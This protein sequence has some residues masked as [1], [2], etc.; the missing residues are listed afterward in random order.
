MTECGNISRMSVVK[1]LG[2][3]LVPFFKTVALLY[4][5]FPKHEQSVTYCVFKC[6]PILCLMG[7]V[8]MYGI[9]LPEK[10]S[11]AFKVLLG[12][13]FSCI[14]DA[15]LVWTPVY[16]K[17]GMLFFA[18]AHLLYVAA[19]G[20]HPPALSL[21][22]IV[23]S[24]IVGVWLCCLSGLTGIYHVVGP[25][26]GL[27]LGLMIWRAAAQVFKGGHPIPWTSISRALGA[28]L[29]GV[30]DAI[31][32]LDMFFAHGSPLS[33]LILPTYYAAQLCITVSVAELTLSCNGQQKKS[34]RPKFLKYRDRLLPIPY[35]KL[36][37]SL[38]SEWSV[39]EQRLC[40][41]LSDGDLI[42]EL[43]EVLCSVESYIQCHG[44]RMPKAQRVALLQLT[45]SM[46]CC[47]NLDP[48]VCF[49][50]VSLSRLLMTRMK[51]LTTKSMQLDWRH[52]YD[53][54]QWLTATMEVRLGLLRWP[55]NEVEKLIKMIRLAKRFFPISSI[56]EIWLDFRHHIL[57]RMLSGYGQCTFD[58]LRLLVPFSPKSFDVIS[59]TWLPDIIDLWYI[60][61]DFGKPFHDVVGILAQVARFCR[62]RVDWEPHLERVFCGL[63]RAITLPHGPVSMDDTGRMQ[64]RSSMLDPYAELLANAIG[65]DQSKSKSTV[66]ER[67]KDFYKT[68]EPFYHPSNPRSSTALLISFSHHLVSS[69]Y[70]RL[71]DELMPAVEQ[72]ED[73]GLPPTEFNLTV[74]QIDEVVQLILPIVLDHML[75]FKYDRTVIKVARTIDFLA[76][77]RPR[78]VLPALLN[79]LED[80]LVRVESPLRYTRPLYALCF[81]VSS[82][83]FVRFGLYQRGSRVGTRSPDSSD[84]DPEDS[85]S[86]SDEPSDLVEQDHATDEVTDL[87][88]N[89]LGS[90]LIDD[91]V[92]ASKGHK[93]SYHSG[94]L[95]PS[96]QAHL[97]AFTFPE[98]RIELV[99][100]LNLLLSGFDLDYTDRVYLTIA[101]LSRL[102]LSTPIQDF[103]EL[104]ADELMNGLDLGTNIRARAESIA[105]STADVEELV[106][107]VFQRTLEYLLALSDRSATGQN[108]TG[109][110]ASAQTD[111]S[112]GSL[113][114]RPHAGPEGRPRV[115]SEVCQLSGLA[116]LSVA[117][118]IST[119]PAPHLRRRLIR[120]LVDV[121]VNS[122]WEP[123][124]ARLL[125][126]QLYWLSVKSKCSVA[127]QQHMDEI[128]DGIPIIDTDLFALN[129]LWPQFVAIYRELHVDGSIVY[130]GRAEPRLLAL[131]YVLSGCFGAI[132]PSRIV[133]A[134]FSR[135][136]LEPLV[137]ILSELLFLSTGVR[138]GMSHQSKPSAVDKDVTG[139]A[140]PALAEAA[141]SLLG[142]ILCRLASY[143]V[144]LSNV[145]LMQ[146]G[147]RHNTPNNLFLN[148]AW[149]TPFI[150]I[151]SLVEQAVSPCQSDEF[152]ST[153]GMGQTNRFASFWVLPSAETRA[154]ADQLVRQF[155]API[156]I[157]LEQINEHLSNSQNGFFGLTVADR[158]NHLSSLLIWALH[159]LVSL[160]DT[161]SPRSSDCADTDINS[162]PPWHGH[163]HL[164]PNQERSKK[165]LL[166]AELLPTLDFSYFICV[167]T[168]ARGEQIGLRDWILDV[169]LNLLTKAAD[170][171][172]HADDSLSGPGPGLISE[173]VAPVSSEEIASSKNKSLGVA[174]D[175]N[176]TSSSLFCCAHLD[177]LIRLTECAAFNWTTSE[178][179]P[180]MLLITRGPQALCL[181]DLGA[182][183]CL[184]PHGNSNTYDLIPTLKLIPSLV[185]LNGTPC[186]QQSLSDDMSLDIDCVNTFG[187]D[188][189][190]SVLSWIATVQKRYQLLSAHY[191][192]YPLN[193]AAAQHDS[194]WAWSSNIAPSPVLKRLIHVMATLA[195]APR[196]YD[197]RRCFTNYLVA[198]PLVVIPRATTE[199]TL[200]VLNRLTN[201]ETDVQSEAKQ[202]WTTDDEE[203]CKRSDRMFKLIHHRRRSSI[204]LLGRIFQKIDTMRQHD[205]FV[206]LD[207]TVMS[208]MWTALIIQAMHHAISEPEDLGRS[209]LS[210]EEIRY[211]QTAHDE[212][213]RLI[214]D[215]FGRVPRIPLIPTLHFPTLKNELNVK[216]CWLQHV[217]Q[218]ASHVLEVFHS[219]NELHT[220]SHPLMPNSPTA[221]V[222]AKRRSVYKQFI[223]DVFD[224]CLSTYQ[225]H[226]TEANQKRRVAG[227]ALVARLFNLLPR[228]IDPPLNPPWK[229]NCVQ[230][231]PPPPAP[232]VPM[233]KVSCDLITSQQPEIAHAACTYV[234]DMLCLLL[235]RHRTP[236]L[237]EVNLNT[238]VEQR[239]GE[240]PPDSGP[241]IPAPRADNLFLAFDEHACVLASDEAFQRHHHIS[242]WDVGY[243]YFPPKVILDDPQ[244]IMAYPVFDPTT[245]LL[246]ETQSDW[247][248]HLDPTDREQ[249]EVRTC[250]IHLA[251]TLASPRDETRQFWLLLG[252]R[253][254]KLHRAPTKRE[255]FPINLFVQI[256]LLAFGPDPLLHHLEALVRSILLVQPG[257]QEKFD[258]VT[259]VVAPCWALL[260]TLN[261]TSSALRWPRP[262]RYYYL[263]RVLPRLLTL[264]ELNALTVSTNG[265]AQAASCNQIHPG[266]VQLF[267]SP[268]RYAGNYGGIGNHGLSDN[269]VP[270]QSESPTPAPCSPGSK[271]ETHHHSTADPIATVPQTQAGGPIGRLAFAW[272]LLF[273][274]LAENGE[275]DISLLH[276]LWDWTQEGID[277]C[278][279]EL[280]GKPDTTGS[281][282]GHNK[283]AVIPPGCL[284]MS[285]GNECPTCLCQRCLPVAHRR[286]FY[287]RMCTTLVTYMGWKGVRLH[288][289]LSNCLP[290]GHPEVHGPKDPAWF[291]HAADNSV[292]IRDT[293][294]KVA[295]YRACLP[296]TDVFHGRRVPLYLR[297]DPVVVNPTGWKE[298][299]ARFPDRERFLTRLLVN[300]QSKELVGS[301]FVTETFLPYLVRDTITVLRLKGY[302]P[303]AASLALRCAPP[304]PS[305][306]NESNASG[307]L[308]AQQD[309]AVAVS[310]RDKWIEMTPLANRLR[311]MY[312]CLPTM[313]SHAFPVSLRPDHMASGIVEN[314]VSALQFCHMLMPLL[315]D[316]CSTGNLYRTISHLL[317]MGTFGSAGFARVAN[318][319]T[320]DE[321]LDGLESGVG[322]VLRRFALIPLAGQGDPDTAI[323]TCLDLARPMLAHG[324]WKTRG[325]GLLLLRNLVVVNLPAFWVTRDAAAA[326]TVFP[327]V[328]NSLR[329]VLMTHL[330]DQWIEVRQL[331]MCTLAVFI[332]VGL[333]NFDPKWVAQLVH[334][335]RTQYPRHLGPEA[336]GTAMMAEYHRAIR[337]RHAGILGLAA[338]VHAHPHT[339]P[340]YL[341]QIITELV[342]HVHDPQPIGKTVSDT[343]AAYSRNHQ[344]NW[345]EQRHK[346]TEEQLEDYM[347]VVSA[348]AYYV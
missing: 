238:Y 205:E 80:G 226:F 108:V 65:P 4:V 159:L 133:Q 153:N 202:Y 326:P 257:S 172:V 44:L 309:V 329:T 214:F 253:V 135:H 163:G 17:H 235:L 160:A 299:V 87:L 217:Y 178:P 216:G 165:G 341:P 142:V 281:C 288:G 92:D 189:G 284:N 38:V 155:L 93:I 237:T 221:N 145:D 56:E 42:Y 90:L 13:M 228:P 266:L 151:R 51:T 74:D 3:R 179:A 140:C 282:C 79:R 84:P 117:L 113:L 25:V 225:N 138:T 285:A 77:L 289:Y 186:P 27:I 330:A 236:P 76:R 6:A 86:E 119:G 101:C 52:F 125:A 203:D 130:R 187:R 183:A 185:S 210:P 269:S 45:L 20:F 196:R 126:Y 265:L 297:P 340:D 331:A 115:A 344:D 71:K 109:S 62:G 182:R 127:A 310:E 72:A 278:H 122:Q 206:R 277:N 184:T 131:L 83:S 314:R 11:Y 197:I 231:A 94:L 321:V 57:E 254:L 110:A 148:T 128:D 259:E 46:A 336:Q 54:F 33:V 2:P 198:F 40:R 118:A 28:A 99:R 55:R 39:I 98:G 294:A 339:T 337:E 144:D 34:D 295:V 319:G 229:P 255:L 161:L 121:A 251:Q 207:P 307:D 141:S 10:R 134:E 234:A 91:T 14:G 30:S 323:C 232:P 267:F 152:D 313:L 129:C 308:S 85:D 102:F 280:C 156:I 315:A 70:F 348:A 48:V 320:G 177:D 298:T 162:T 43:P 69:L 147:S 164:E 261:T 200:S 346:F 67:L 193:R 286:V 173:G 201:A 246:D 245:G 334:Q 123:D 63:L 318:D 271:S 169:G 107:R 273:C 332:Q 143:S 260:I 37:A 23:L 176:H 199:I 154:L 312:A 317:S 272:D 61:T 124:T 264:L 100:L 149:W 103:S 343:L 31:L 240:K 302:E 250:L 263:G 64:T 279:R 180:S 68:V 60:I 347:S 276:P 19:F 283:Q 120:L 105:S 303:S 218:Q 192:R 248:K 224:R 82:L 81:C 213:E 338:F 59:R 73:L 174:M 50:A 243:I 166:A 333:I 239:T 41:V 36:D 9:R 274:W 150:S 111:T 311:C 89:G 158:R 258:G 7:F 345:H 22:F 293:A 116:G 262:W 175:G 32:S 58:F 252:Q 88:D 114:H 316:L 230:L 194:N 306:V 204:S 191:L 227:Q 26:Y 137:S 146:S 188:I 112:N 49:R 256:C 35:S 157:R 195:T 8:L 1:C 168:N 222:I 171:F 300:D 5:I 268:L 78:L 327:T 15:F 208:N 292:W 328:V 47:P 12:L 75:F 324:S 95:S 181:P 139:F 301:Q 242:P 66:I 209:P 304:E 233:L 291:N 244:H 167:L 241:P 29:F 136:Y 325:V 296:H 170:L 18:L 96:G 215:V 305:L 270:A 106:V 223:T 24:V 275:F 190:R 247:L 287:A 249:Q 21:L 97:K 322:I 53:M 219:R 211:R 16:L 132:H 104:S 290:T 212:I 220:P 335:T 342:G